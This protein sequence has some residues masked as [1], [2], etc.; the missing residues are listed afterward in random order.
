MGTWT[1]GRPWG[2]ASE[3]VVKYAS[4]KHAKGWSPTPPHHQ[5]ALTDLPPEKADVES[6]LSRDRAVYKHGCTYLTLW[7]WLW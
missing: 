5:Q 1:P 2:E 7:E 4:P 3:A 6:L